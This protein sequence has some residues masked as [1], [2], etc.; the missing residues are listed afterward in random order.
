M[1][2]THY[3]F[4]STFGGIQIKATESHLI[5]L[6]F[7]NQP[8][9]PMPPPSA[10][11]AEAESQIQAFLRG[12]LLAFDLPMDIRVD[13]FQKEVLQQVLRIPYGKTST[14]R[15]LARLVGRNS[16]ARAVGRANA[17]NPLPLL[18]PCHRVIGT[19][20][21]LTGYTGGLNRKQQFLEME[22]GAQQ[23]TFF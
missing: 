21:S 9:P 5:Q 18:I 11:L 23:L 2:I 22:A 19:D 8:P 13:D 1:P 14:Y 17:L 7:L 15:E 10:L 20:G 12:E 16:H 3:Q 6:A 4:R